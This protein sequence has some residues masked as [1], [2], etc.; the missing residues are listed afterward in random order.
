MRKVC[1]CISQLVGIPK[2]FVSRI[3]KESTEIS[4]NLNE[5]SSMAEKQHTKPYKCY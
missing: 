1:E 5:S 2:W 3:L 4:E